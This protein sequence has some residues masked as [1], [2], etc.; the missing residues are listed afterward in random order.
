MDLIIVILIFFIVLVP[1]VM[2]A[3]KIGEYI[4][5]WLEDHFPD[6]KE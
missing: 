6:V 4:E 3:N 5:H 1:V 2:V